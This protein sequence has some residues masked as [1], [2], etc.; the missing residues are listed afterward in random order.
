MLT[1]E[2]PVEAF[3]M[4]GCGGDLVVVGHVQ[5]HQ[6]NAGAD[7]A[8]TEPLDCLVSPFDVS[9]AENVRIGRIAYASD[10]NDREAEALVGSCDQH[11]LGSIPIHGVRV[12]G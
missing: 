10:F 1:V 5:L 9:R 12:K 3:H 11:D 8:V 7:S 2:T 6:V 4:S